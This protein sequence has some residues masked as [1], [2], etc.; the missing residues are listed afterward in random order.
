M[1]SKRRLGASLLF[2]GLAFVGAFHTVL[3]LAFD[4]GLTTIGAGIAIG[5][6]LCLVAV[7]VPAL[8]D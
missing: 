6:L 3:S 5:S 7:N 1:V 4:T 2:L 8:L